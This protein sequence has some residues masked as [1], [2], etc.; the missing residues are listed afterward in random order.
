MDQAAIDEPVVHEAQAEPSLEASWQPGDVQGS[1]ETE[2]A[3]DAEPEM[4]L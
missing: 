3:E 2:A 4:E 1:Y